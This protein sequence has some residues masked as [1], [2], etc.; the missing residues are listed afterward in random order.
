VAAALVLGIEPG[1]ENEAGQAGADHL[2]AEGED[3]AVVVLAREGGGV[4]LTAVD[5]ADAGQLV[6][7]DGHAHAGAADEQS[8]GRDAALN[9]T[10]DFF[11]KARVV[12]AV[13][14]VGAVVFKSH[15]ALGEVGFEGFF[16]VVADVVGAESEGGE[17]HEGPFCSGMGQRIEPI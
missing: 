3:V 12:R 17:G 2:R 10:G 9:D 7:S 1:P 4:G 16:E 5:G 13:A 8:A 6:G 11:G 14:A 15:A